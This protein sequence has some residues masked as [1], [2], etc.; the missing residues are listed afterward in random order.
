MMEKIRYICNRDINR[1]KWDYCIEHSIN[2]RIYAMTWYLDIVSEQWDCIVYGDYKLVFPVVFKSRYFFKKSYSPLF[3]QQLGFF[4]DDIDLI[5]DHILISDMV[6]CLKRRFKYSVQFSVTSEI[7]SNIFNALKWGSSLEKRINIELSL[8]KDYLALYNSYSLNIKR[9]L[10]K[11][12]IQMLSLKEASDVDFFINRFKKHVGLKVKLNQL[13]YKIISQ[14]MNIS[15]ERGIGKLFIVLN[16]DSTII[17][18]AFIISF[19]TRD[20]LLFNYSD[21]QFKRLDAMTF[22]LDRYINKNASLNKILDFEGSNL[23]G[24]KRF[25]MSFGGLQTLYYLFSKSFF[26]NR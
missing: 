22:L 26:S 21:P 11:N 23:E 7:S 8:N 2:T 4:T 1:V 5:N 10:K 15:I 25:Y 16:K 3:C 13:N 17:A 12:S 24:V 19:Q 20:I 6:N 14:I 18:S 9:K